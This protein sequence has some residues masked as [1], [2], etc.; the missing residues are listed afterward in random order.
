MK[1]I[2]LLAILWVFTSAVVPS[3]LLAQEKKAKDKIEQPE[4][5]GGLKALHKYLTSELRFPE[6]TKHNSSLKEALVAFT[7]GVD[8]YPTSV[9][10]LRTS[11]SELLDK[12]IL[13]VIGN[14]GYWYPGKKNGKPVRFEMSMPVNCKVL[15]DHG[16]YINE[17]G[18]GSTVNEN[19]LKEIF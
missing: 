15:F 11:G 17:D 12:E 3:T 10:I 2:I 13:R 4:Y 7:I 6:E 14:S 19:V 16:K 8:G 5:P 9:R 18:D 1:K